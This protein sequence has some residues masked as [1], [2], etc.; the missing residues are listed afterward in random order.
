MFKNFTDATTTNCVGWWQFDEGTGTTAEDL[1]P[2][3]TDF[4]VGTLAKSAEASWAG[5]GSIT[6][7]WRFYT[8]RWYFKYDWC[9]YH[10][11]F[12]VSRRN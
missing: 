1:S 7:D 6:L 10:S 3:G 9:R 8:K 2:N 5:A 11:Y 4:T 12:N